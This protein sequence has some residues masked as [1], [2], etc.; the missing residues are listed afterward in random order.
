MVTPPARLAV[1]LPISGV[2][3]G[4]G[5]QP[6]DEIAGAAELVQGKIDNVPLAVVRGIPSDPGWWWQS[7]PLAEWDGKPR[8]RTSPPR[9]R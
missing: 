5:N 8:R 7:A 2:M 9:W 1:A 3:A 4:R 6:A